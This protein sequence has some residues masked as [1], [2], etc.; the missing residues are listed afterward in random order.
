MDGRLMDTLF[1]NRL[2]YTHRRIIS[3]VFHRVERLL[4]IGP[5]VLPLNICFDRANLKRKDAKT[6]GRTK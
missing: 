3:F 2:I 5:I 4:G 6:Q 1:A